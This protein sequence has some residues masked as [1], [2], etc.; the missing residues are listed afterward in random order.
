MYHLIWLEH[1]YSGYNIPDT[2]ELLSFSTLKEVQIFIK[3]KLKNTTEYYV[4]ENG[5]ILDPH[6]ATEGAD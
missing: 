2:L 3:E 4:I 6:F 5:T 1:V